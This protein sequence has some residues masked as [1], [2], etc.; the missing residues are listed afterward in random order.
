MTNIARSVS[1]PTPVAISADELGLS[2][3]AQRAFRIKGERDIPKVIT[4]ERAYRFARKVGFGTN[5]YSDYYVEAWKVVQERFFPD[6][7]FRYEDGVLR[8][9]QVQLREKGFA[10]GDTAR[11][12]AFEGPNG[13]VPYR[14]AIRMDGID[15]PE[16]NPSSKLTKVVQYNWQYYRWK[17]QIPDRDRS[18]A[19]AIIKA[20]VQYL[21]KIAGA[22]TNAFHAWV[23]NERGNVSLGPA[24][25]R[26]AAS[27]IMCNTLDLSDKFLRFIGRIKAGLPGQEADLLAGF[28]RTLLP[29]YMQQVRQDLLA[30]YAGELSKQG[31]FMAGLKNSKP[32]LFELFAAKFAPDPGEIFSQEECQRLESMWRGFTDDHPE[33]NNDLQTLLAFLGVAPPYLKYRGHMSCVDILAE[34]YSLGLVPGVSTTHGLVSANHDDVYMIGM[35]RIDEPAS[36]MFSDE[37]WQENLSDGK[38]L[39]PPDCT[40]RGA[41][42]LY[43]NG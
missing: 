43:G 37:R 22:V 5:V 20:R 38:N 36:R 42:I 24:Y 25:G 17:F 41:D 35:P 21:G 10:D 29:Q 30:G 34:R 11:V 16:S 33:A 9:I 19:Q 6:I 2:P 40:V 27:Q 18:A 12:A 26:A 39:N 15:T 23:K 28:V 14:A 8:P 1:M 3:N 7:P 13:W 32:E 4:T 31:A